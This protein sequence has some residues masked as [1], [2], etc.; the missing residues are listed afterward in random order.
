MFASYDPEDLVAANGWYVPVGVRWIMVFASPF[1][2]LSH[3][4]PLRN[5]QS[6][7]LGLPC[8]GTGGQVK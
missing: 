3:V 2:L 7:D 6:A 4:F 5:R 8:G 1:S